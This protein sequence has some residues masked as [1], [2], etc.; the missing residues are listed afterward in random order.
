M[1]ILFFLEF[2]V[3]S[4]RSCTFMFAIL[5]DPGSLD[6][7]FYNGILQ[8]WDLDISF[9]HRILEILHPELVLYHWILG[10][11]Y[12]EFVFHHWILKILVLG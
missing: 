4:S 2:I 12:P 3:E 10:I 8:I 6:S 9:H 1:W 11:L 7:D 5:S